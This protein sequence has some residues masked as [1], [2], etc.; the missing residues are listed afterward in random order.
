VLYKNSPLSG[1]FFILLIHG[2]IKMNFVSGIIY[3]LIQLIQLF[4]H[5]DI[6]SGNTHLYFWG[7]MEHIITPQIIRTSEDNL[8]SDAEGKFTHDEEKHFV[9]IVP[10][11]KAL[12]EKEAVFYAFYFLSQK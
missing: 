1:E 3:Q 8:V 12:Y 2:S 7:V 11:I 10:E 4:I 9:E 5:D 6:D